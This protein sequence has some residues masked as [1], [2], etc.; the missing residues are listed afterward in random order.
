L[1]TFPPSL[2]DPVRLHAEFRRF[3]VDGNGTLSRSELR[4]FMRSASVQLP[5]KD[6]DILINDADRNGDGQIAFEEFVALLRALTAARES[7]RSGDSRELREAFRRLDRDGNGVLDGAEIKYF[8]LEFGKKN[9]LS[10]A[11]V[12]R[13]LA[14]ADRN[15]DGVINYDEFLALTQAVLLA[16]RVRNPHDN[17]ELRE[18]FKKLDRDHSR[19][20]TP[21][22]VRLFAMALQYGH[23]VDIDERLV[24]DLIAECDP[25]GDRQ[26]DYHEFERLFT[27]YT[28][29][30]AV[31]DP[32]DPD[33]AWAVFNRLDTD[34]AGHLC[35]PELKVFLRSMVEFTHDGEAIT[36][37]V[38]EAMLRPS[39]RDKWDFKAFEKVLASLKHY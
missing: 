10:K 24:D 5:A 19:Y 20:L 6:L 13:L 39:D 11:E 15:N 12:N 2:F 35:R 16:K 18:A 26:I 29:G 38:A 14:E 9:G 23:Q 8:A 1:W 33:E 3:D 22:E 17:F 7:V 36:E 34:N 28:A 4:S 21:S 25:D 37:Q 31:R 32:Q 27:A 30:Q